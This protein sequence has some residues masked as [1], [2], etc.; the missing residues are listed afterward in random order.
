MGMTWK[1][2][3][4]ASACGL[5]VCGAARADEIYTFT[6]TTAYY[7]YPG[8]LASTSSPPFS[9]GYDL[10]DAAVARGAFALSNSGPIN[11]PSFA[12]NLTGDTASLISLN[13]NGDMVRPGYAQAEFSTEL[14][15]DASGNVTSTSLSTSGYSSDIRLSGTGIDA[16][17]VFGSDQ[18]P[19]CELGSSPC[20]VSGYWTRTG[21]PLSAP[22]PEPASLALLG[23]GVL[24][25]AAARRRRTVSPA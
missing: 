10:T 15:F 9:L 8:N 3:A 13:L 16:S 24:G 6:A 4:L 19:A 11:Y 17:G 2:L 21:D 12:A 18:A 7:T 23:A 5:V 1:A 14:T 20:S 22:V 25:L